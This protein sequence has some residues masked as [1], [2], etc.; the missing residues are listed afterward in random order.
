MR[1]QILR[2]STAIFFI[3]LGLAGILPQIDESVFSLGYRKYN[4]EVVFGVIEVLCGLLLLAGFW[5][6][7]RDTLFKVTIAVLVIWLVRLALSQFIFK[8]WPASFDAMLGRLIVVTAEL[9]IASSLW[10]LTRSYD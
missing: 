2:I 8:A 6:S 1:V 7:S 9:V 10:T 3:C 5:L 4:L